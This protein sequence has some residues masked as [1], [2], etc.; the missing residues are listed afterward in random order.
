MAVSQ[1][2]FQDVVAVAFVP[3]NWQQRQRVW[4]VHSSV[5]L[6]ADFPGDFVATAKMSLERTASGALINCRRYAGE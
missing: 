3:A 5:K 4:S 6:P 1:V 2:K